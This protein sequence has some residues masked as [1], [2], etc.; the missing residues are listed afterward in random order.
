MEVHLCKTQAA[1]ADHFTIGPQPINYGSGQPALTVG[2]AIMNGLPASVSKLAADQPPSFTEFLFANS[3]ATTDS[4]QSLIGL[5]PSTFSL[6]SISSNLAGLSS[7]LSQFATNAWAAASAGVA[8]ETPA[9]V[10]IDLLEDVVLMEVDRIRTGLIGSGLSTAT[11]S[12]IS[13]NLVTTTYSGGGQSTQNLTAASE[14]YTNADGTTGKISVSWRGINFAQ[15]ISGG[16][17]ELAFIDPDDRTDYL[18][19]AGT[20]VYAGANDC[21]TLVGGSGVNNYVVQATAAGGTETIVDLMVR[22]PFP[23]EHR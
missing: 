23:L 6:K 8:A 15:T 21:D 11:N 2:D 7:S 10:K 16:M 17:T 5:G 18:S 20:A 19:G 13:G 4:I 9:S 12:S 22:V 1:G 3:S 14:T